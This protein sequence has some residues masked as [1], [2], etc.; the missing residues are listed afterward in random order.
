MKTLDMIEK[1]FIEA[2]MTSLVKFI[3]VNLKNKKKKKIFQNLKELKKKKKKYG[4]RQRKIL[5]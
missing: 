3:Y 1:I 5:K 2:Q 4:L